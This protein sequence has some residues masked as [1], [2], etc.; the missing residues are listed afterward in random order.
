MKSKFPWAYRMSAD[1]VKALFADCQLFFDTSTLLRLYSIPKATAAKV[2]KSIAKYK[3]RVS[4]PFHVA[5]EYHWHVIEHLTA[6]ISTT[7]KQI[8]KFDCK[9][10]FSQLFN[11]EFLNYLPE[12]DKAPYLKLV[13]KFCADAN[14][15]LRQRQK[16]CEEEFNSMEIAN[17]LA[18]QLTDCILPSLPNDEILALKETFKQRLADE[19]PPGFKDKNKDKPEKKRKGQT[20]EAGDYIIWCEILK[21]S[22]TNNKNVI[23]ISNE[24]KT[25]WIWEEHGFRIGPRWELK[26][27]FHNT[28]G[29]NTFHIIDLN[30]FLRLTDDEYTQA[31]LKSTEP[32]A[33]PAPSKSSRPKSTI[34]DILNRY[35]L[36]STPLPSTPADGFY[37][38]L[39]Q[40]QMSAENARQTLENAYSLDDYNKAIELMRSMSRFKPRQKSNPKSHSIDFT[41]LLFSDDDFR[42]DTPP[43]TPLI[44]PTDQSQ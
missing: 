15:L 20:N 25:D 11:S 3:A 6:R 29:G 23:L 7:Q 12:E 36:E 17:S 40:S 16:D 5:E 14:K 26:E 42:D 2:V 32:P 35:S 39:L 1:E 34:L 24:K 13:D 4:I 27:E 41:P 37:D 28:S 21:W 43:A 22:Q 30:T 19:I 31:E 44:P 33:D 10:I 8:S 9:T 18:D 38:G